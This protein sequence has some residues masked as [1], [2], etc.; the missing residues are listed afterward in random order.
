[1]KR[2]V[3]EQTTSG[4]VLGTYQADSPG[5]AIR[6]MIEDAGD[7]SDVGE[8]DNGLV[9]TEIAEGQPDIELD[10]AYTV[11]DG[12]AYLDGMVHTSGGKWVSYDTAEQHMDDDLREK[13]HA[14]LS[15]CTAQEFFN[16]YC[17][18]HLNKFGKRF[19]ADEDNPVW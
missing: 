15:P 16:E 12:L 11:I 5:H 9:A 17:R 19:V 13:I 3:V 18:S 2:Y 6:T 1:M 8:P 14:D 4:Y 7:N 10:T